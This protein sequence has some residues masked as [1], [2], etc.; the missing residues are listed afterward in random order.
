MDTLLCPHN[1]S[2]HEGPSLKHC[3][4]LVHAARTGSAAALKEIVSNINISKEDVHLSM[5]NLFNGK[6]EG[7]AE[8][9]RRLLA[10]AHT[11]GKHRE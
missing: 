7:D 9:L 4:L 8:A 11:A 2:S 3:A 1:S 6:G 5:K 10:A